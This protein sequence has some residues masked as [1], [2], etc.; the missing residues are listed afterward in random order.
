MTSTTRP[1]QSA[2]STPSS[3]HS[4]DK[5]IALSSGPPH[6]PDQ[7]PDESTT[8]GAT[9]GLS[10][11]SLHD[12]WL[13]AALAGSLEE[14][15]AFC[16]RHGLSGSSLQARLEGLM[17]L[18]NGQQTTDQD[19][20]ESAA[21]AG[22]ARSPAAETLEPDDDLP[23]E[24]IGGYRLLR[25][26][27]VGGMGHVYLAEQERLGRLVA[28]KIIRPELA[29]SPS[30]VERFR[31]EARAIAKLRHPHVVTV[32]DAGED[33]NI[34]WF[35][36]ELVPGR[37]L[38]EVL[39]AAPQ[40]L[41]ARRVVAWA[42]DLARA[43]DAAHREG[44]VHR[45]VKPGNVRI[46]S[47]DL[48]LLLDFG[49][50]RDMTGAD[51]TITAAFAGSPAYAAPEQ[52]F[53]KP[54][55]G[56]TDVYALGVTL[57]Q[58]LS[59]QVPFEADSLAQQIQALAADDPPPLRSLRPELPRDL[60]V[61]VAKAMER[62]P[63]HRYASAAALADDLDA[64][65]AL[66]PVSAVPPGPIRRAWSW[67][68]RHRAMAASLVALL[69]VGVVTLVTSVVRDMASS[70]ADSAEAARL[71]SDALQQI[72][73]YADGRAGA[74]AAKW[75]D[76]ALS[77]S[78]GQRLLTPAETGQLDEAESIG[79]AHDR[80][81]EQLVAQV[82]GQ[83]AEA[84][85]LD[86]QAP[87]LEL[88]WTSFAYQRWLDVR[89]L[90][91]AGTERFFRDEVL[92][93][94]PDG[95]W[96]AKVR[97]T[98]AITFDS[99]P[100]GAKVYLFRYQEQGDLASGQRR[101][102]VAMP[103]LDLAGADTKVGSKAQEP[104]PVPACLLGT[105]PMQT[106]QLLPGWYVAWLE[107]PGLVPQALPFHVDHAVE[108]YSKPIRLAPRLIT[109]DEVV[110]GFVRV[111]ADA[112][113][114]GEWAYWMQRREVTVAEYSAY[115]TDLAARDPA[116]A[117]ARLPAA[118]DAEQPWQLDPQGR[119]SVPSDV[120]PD[121][122]VLGVSWT[123]ALAY[124]HWWDETLNPRPAELWA[125]LPALHEW[126]RAGHGGDGRAYPF[127]D[128][129][130]PGWVS[131]RF[132]TEQ[133]GPSPVGSHPVDRSPWGLLDMAGSAREWLGDDLETGLR[134]LAGGGWDEADPWA[135]R[136]QRREDLPAENRG[137]STGFRMV[138]RE[139][140]G[141]GIAVGTTPTFTHPGPTGDSA[142]EKGQAEVQPHSAATEAGPGDVP[143]RDG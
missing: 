3:D 37:S 132:S 74:D 75:T 24:R 126:I 76:L 122:P 101:T 138:L 39:D 11:D 127:G 66:R 96:S 102:L 1:L 33:D 29:A 92:A 10:D 95:S 23:R 73:A 36:M 69:L 128:V 46:T 65:L 99:S 14:P 42:R 137:R 121:H 110:S 61:V 72:T 35:A 116:A 88:A 90:H 13:D 104:G 119:V 51:V 134:I 97:G 70:R 83:L 43:L 53:G 59:G 142:D 139:R 84:R 58:S 55:D 16:A 129:F 141:Y 120:A 85:R 40:P 60:V 118:L 130:R 143:T 31:R 87:D 21:P 136:I 117:R 28:L 100:S 6:R 78:I 56:R 57:Y 135:F 25:L 12:A 133:Q 62:E 124:T 54:V 71:V 48:A 63:G 86:D 140:E 52:L 50:A 17:G 80:A 22:L 30:V 68:R 20:P 67:A 123:D 2:R 19:T 18:L 89:G 93:H 45:D 131:S 114:W 115:V 44:I 94:D 26:L 113:P 125:D 15:Q 98:A 27:G 77:Q 47:D 112:Y 107:A 49:L 105:T 106:L 79:R 34:L 7:S 103:V 108:L 8:R 32:L 38:S 4:G 41:P 109:P 111:A 91:A 9:G 64:V 81:R 5:I 82:L